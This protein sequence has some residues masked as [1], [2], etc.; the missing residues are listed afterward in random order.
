MSSISVLAAEKYSSYSGDRH[1]HDITARQVH[2]PR[3]TITEE[4]CSAAERMLLAIVLFALQM[5]LV[6]TLVARRG[7]GCTCAGGRECFWVWPLGLFIERHRY[8]AG[9]VL[10]NCGG[11]TNDLTILWCG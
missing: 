11:S 5:S 8:M 4:S 9:K 10:K 7:S 1:T 2:T 6:H 3:D